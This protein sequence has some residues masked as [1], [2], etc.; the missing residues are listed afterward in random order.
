MREIRGR[1][2]LVIGASG[3]LGAPVARALRAE[4]AELIVSGRNEAV[5]KEL[6]HELDAAAI[7]ADL[8]DL[9]QVE[10]I[11]DEAGEVDILVNAAGIIFYPAFTEL[12][13]QEI[14][15]GIAVNLTSPMLLVHRL[16]PGMLQ[17]GRGHVVNISSLAGYA[18]PA[19]QA[20]YA[21]TKAAVVALTR[22]LRAEHHGTPVGFS[23]VSP[24]YV[25]DAGV[26]ADNVARHGLRSPR[27][28]GTV[29]P[30]KVARAVVRAIRRDLPEVVVASSPVRVLFVLDALSP[31]L[32]DA[33]VRWTG[34]NELQRRAAELHRE[35]YLDT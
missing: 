6:S 23:V 13:R 7:V 29:R 3:G 1:R 5:L 16:L 18:N 32:G 20:V 9:A 8:A 27:L 2:A 21:A 17:R 19:Y 28:V 30:E 12:P 31:R 35:D 26:Y 34:V 14:E 25:E 11:A 15:R 10:R 22:S 4:G 33:M 24:V